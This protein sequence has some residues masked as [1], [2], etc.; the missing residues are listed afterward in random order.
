MC[1]PFTEGE[2]DGARV[3]QNDDDQWCGREDLEIELID[4]TPEEEEAER[5]K[6]DRVG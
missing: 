1:F 6:M 2:P 5:R 3:L 4:L